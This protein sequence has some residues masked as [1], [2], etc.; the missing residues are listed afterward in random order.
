MATV[1]IHQAM[2]HLSRLIERVLAGE[3]I[4]LS[5]AVKPVARLVPFDR[6]DK[7]RIPDQYAGQIHIPDAFESTTDQEIADFHGEAQ[8]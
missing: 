7:R 5:R 2:T 4:I 6:H 1:D 3:E 8:A